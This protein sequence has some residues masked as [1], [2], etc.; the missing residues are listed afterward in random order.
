MTILAQGQSGTLIRPVRPQT[1]KFRQWQAQAEKNRELSTARFEQRLLLH[2]PPSKASQ[3]AQETCEKPQY[4][5]SP[6]RISSAHEQHCCSNPSL[7]QGHG[8]HMLADSSVFFVCFCSLHCSSAFSVQN[9]L[10]L[11]TIA[12][13]HCPQRLQPAAQLPATAA[14]GQQAPS[15]QHRLVL[16]RLQQQAESN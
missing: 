11:L 9:R 13:L 4:F 8:Y 15:I 14:A 16:S 7:A 1:V 5:D 2:P 12:P 6:A 3:S 10:V